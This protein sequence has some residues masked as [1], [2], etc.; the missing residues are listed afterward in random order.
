MNITIFG[1]GYVG[2]VTAACF[3][4]AGNDVLCVD[5]D[6]AKVAMLRRGESPIYEPG[7]TEMLKANVEENELG[8]IRALPPERM[9]AWNR[10]PASFALM[11]LYRVWSRNHTHG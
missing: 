5:V 7:L 11:W 10:R 6:A 3:A 2:L 9:I 4:D 8:D 1:S